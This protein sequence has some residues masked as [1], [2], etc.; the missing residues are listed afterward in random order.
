MVDAP[1]VIISSFY[2][3]CITLASPDLTEH[4][5]EIAQEVLQMDYKFLD[6]LISVEF[7]KSNLASE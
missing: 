7:L 2:F 3:G 4:A 5:G 1:N 6:D